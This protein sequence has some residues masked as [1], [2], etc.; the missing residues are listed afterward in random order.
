MRETVWVYHY[1][2]KRLS[3]W[4]KDR[5]VCE[6]DVIEYLIDQHLD[7]LNSVF[8]KVE[9]PDNDLNIKADLDYERRQ[10]ERMGM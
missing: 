1:D 10:D 3:E 5:D 8:P 4:I 2:K 7:D 6:A 9:D